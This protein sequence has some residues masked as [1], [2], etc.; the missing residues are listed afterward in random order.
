MHSGVC[1]YP[2]AAPFVGRKVMRWDGHTPLHWHQTSAEAHTPAPHSCPGG[3]P[4]SPHLA[5]SPTHTT[6]ALCCTT[7]QNKAVRE[8]RSTHLYV[9]S[10]AG[11]NRQGIRYMIYD[12]NTWIILPPVPT[13]QYSLWRKAKQNVSDV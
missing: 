6:N 5:S 7:W 3:P 9:T 8:V 10:N 2:A 4:E 13:L 11:H 1:S 12:S